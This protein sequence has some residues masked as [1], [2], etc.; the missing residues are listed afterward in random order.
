VEALGEKRMPR[1]LPEYVGSW[2]ENEAVAYA[3]QN[4]SAWKRTPGALEWLALG[5]EKG[6]GGISND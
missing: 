6:T 4:R 1:L 3:A 5:R 2:D